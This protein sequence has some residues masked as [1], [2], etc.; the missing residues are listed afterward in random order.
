[1]GGWAG[2]EGGGDGQ[3]RESGEGDRIRSWTLPRSGIVYGGREREGRRRPAA[4]EV[5]RTWWGWGG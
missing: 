3:G 2:R 5:R 1:M 4:G